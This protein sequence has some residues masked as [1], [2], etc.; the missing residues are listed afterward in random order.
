[1]LCRLSAQACHPVRIHSF[2]V[3]GCLTQVRR[4]RSQASRVMRGL[5]WVKGLFKDIFQLLQ[6]FLLFLFPTVSPRQL[7][8]EHADYA[9]VDFDGP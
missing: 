8:S 9:G 1:M 5:G 3:P 6:E 2:V 4:F 7:G